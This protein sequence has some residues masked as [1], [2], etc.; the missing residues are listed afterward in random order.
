[1]IMA[2]MC[3]QMG[4][5]STPPVSSS[6]KLVMMNLEGITMN[7]IIITERHPHPTKNQPN[8]L[9]IKMRATPQQQ[10]RGAAMITT[11]SPYASHD[12]QNHTCVIKS[13]TSSLSRKIFTKLKRNHVSLPLSE[14]NLKFYLILVPGDNPTQLEEPPSPVVTH[15]EACEAVISKE[16]VRQ[17]NSN[18]NPGNN[19]NQSDSSVTPKILIKTKKS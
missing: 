19:M 18:G 14:R 1:M 16:R 10:R 8:L 11:L 2:F 17:Q 15:V 13:T 6:T 4:L 12:P 3:M 9:T 7:K 5:L